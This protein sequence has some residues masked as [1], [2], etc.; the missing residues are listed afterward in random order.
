MSDNAPTHTLYVLP[1]RDA[2]DGK[3]TYA[4]G[5]WVNKDGSINLIVNKP[6]DKG[7][8]LQIRKRRAKAE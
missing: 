3:W 5:G 1:A 8:R 6:V 4:G 7:Q 2:E